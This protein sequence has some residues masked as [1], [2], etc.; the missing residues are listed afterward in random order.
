MALGNIEFAYCTEFFIINI[1]KKTTLADIEK[2]RVNLMNIG[3]SVIVI[4]DL[5]FIK[6]HVHTNKP[7]RAITMALELG[8]IDKVKI[9]NMLEQ[10]RELMKKYEA[11]KKEIGML[12]ISSGDGISAIFKDLLVDGILEGGQ[13]MNPSAADI[14]D[15][16]QRIN[17]DNIFVFPNNKNIILAAEQAKSLVENKKIHVIPTKNIPQ[18]FSAAMTFNP[19]LSVEENKA[20]MIHAMDLVTVGQITYA[21]KNTKIDGFDIKEGDVMGLDSKKILAKGNDIATVAIK[22]IEKMRGA[23]E[24][25]TLYYGADVKEEDAVA[26]S[27]KL[28]EIYPDCDVQ[29]TYGGQPIYYYYISL[30]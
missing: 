15:S 24:I 26:L 20:N 3:D 4:G 7:G 8:E 2:L 29:I 27:E 12:A 9:E 14:A 28:Q 19:E 10:N 6:V 30:E 17:A 23:E 5:E 11:E 25:I 22:L 18:G 16:A 1:K 13:S 21:V